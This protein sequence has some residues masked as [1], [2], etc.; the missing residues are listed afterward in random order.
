[1]TAD[2]GQ[3]GPTTA[4]P[5]RRRWIVRWLIS[6][7]I[8]V[9]TLAW[10]DVRTV[11]DHLRGVKPG[12]AIAALAVS[13]PQI[14]LMAWRWHFTASRVGAG[15]PFSQA[16]RE[17]YVSLLLN[18]VLPGGVVGDVA[19]VVRQADGDARPVGRVAS[20]VVLERASG[21]VVLWL[22]VLCTLP[23]LGRAAPTRPLAVVF[24][25]TAGALVVLALLAR[26][27]PLQQT[28]LGS[29]VAGAQRDL[30]SAFVSRGAFA[31]QLLCS[32]V[33]FALLVVEFWLCSQAIGST[34]SLPV[35]FV[36]VPW[37]LAATSL[38]LTAGGWGVRE[39]AAGGIFGL[40]G[41]PP[42]EAVAIS[43][44]FG[45]VALL[46]VLPGA[47]GLLRPSARSSITREDA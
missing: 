30:A 16:W 27:G 45:A 15:L 23:F 35:T 44:V 32:A 18:Q 46:S 4:P 29:L 47:L 39:A 38:P 9:V 12:W 22:A 41:L 13:V 33:A 21:Q 26:F 2:A 8:L 40:L 10:L 24:G 17:Y 31:I 42:S 3:P 28:R 34:V 36:L 20:S 6:L 25:A 19:R 37:V 7:A 14:G 11:L 43:I 1:M 5:R